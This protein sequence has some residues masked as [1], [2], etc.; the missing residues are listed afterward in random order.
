MLWR[1]GL[2]SADDALALR[3]MWRILQ[4]QTDDYLD[5][6]LGVVAA[7]PAL[8]TVLDSVRIKNPEK[9][10]ENDADIHRLF[11]Q[12]LQETCMAPHELSWLKRGYREWRSSPTAQATPMP[13]PNYRYLIVLSIPLVATARSLLLANGLAAQPAEEMQCALLKA[14]LLQVTL[15]SKLYVREGAW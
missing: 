4:N 3:K 5:M 12:W 2:F 13:L 9:T 6:V 7:Y 10:T 14:I 8:A 1:I 15:L 11:R